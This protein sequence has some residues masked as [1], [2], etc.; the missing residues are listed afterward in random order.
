MVEQATIADYSSVDFRPF[1]GLRVFGALVLGLTPQALRFR[2][3]CRLRC[4]LF[5]VLLL[6]IYY[7]RFTIYYSAVLVT[8]WL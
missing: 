4:L 3:L 8:N 5:A 2:L 6:A 1:H 7:S